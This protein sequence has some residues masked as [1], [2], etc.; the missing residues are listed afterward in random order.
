MAPA[1]PPP[2]MSWLFAGLTMASTSSFVMSPVVTV[3][4]V[5]P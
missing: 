3:I 1:T 2:I 4:F 5:S